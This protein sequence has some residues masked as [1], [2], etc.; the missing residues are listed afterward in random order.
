MQILM[1]NVVTPFKING[2]SFFPM[3]IIDPWTC[4]FGGAKTYVELVLRLEKE[5]EGGRYE[6]LDKLSKSI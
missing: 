3:E 4:K 2:A 6:I 5:S 1:A